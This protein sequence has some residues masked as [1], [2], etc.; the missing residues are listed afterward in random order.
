RIDK[1]MFGI[2]RYEDVKSSE[3][4]LKRIRS[5]YQ[6]AEKQC[7]KVNFDLSITKNGVRLTAADCNSNSVTVEGK[8]PEKA[9]NHAIDE[10]TSKEK[11]S[12]T[13]GT[14]F[15]TGEINVSIE[16]CLAV[17]VSEINSLR[18][19]SLQLLLEKRGRVNSLF[20]DNSVI[21]EVKHIKFSTENKK[22]VEKIR[23]RFRSLDQ[24]PKNLDFSDVEMIVLPL[25]ET[26]DKKIASLIEKHI[27]VAA[28]MPRAIFSNEKK[29]SDLLISAKKFGVND[30]VCG[31]V[32]AI[33]IAEKV[34]FT[35]HGDF[36]LN[37]SNSASLEAYADAGLK[38]GIL[39]F[40]TPFK[41][42]KQISARG[43]IPCG[44]IVYG[45]LPLML[46]R[47]CPVR[48]FKGCIGECFIKDRTNCEFPLVCENGASEI[49]NS[50]PLWL[51]DKKSR[52]LNSGVELFELYF[53][54]ESAAQVENVLERWYKGL[55]CKSEFTRGLY[56]H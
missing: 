19:E 48:S 47:N 23:L 5:L 53:T 20:F 25:K 8:N 1:D 17:P 28:E 27:I 24:I 35:I 2:R 26:A 44:I 21:D 11:L 13:G 16:D 33:N 40:E 52:I 43:I 4:S 9:K 51:C 50:R 41:G 36:G 38:T 18:R 7:V 56:F 45:R 10:K 3:E 42:I 34:N 54:I 49:L 32:G 39:S 22:S 15:F 6:N 30:A 31:N 46:V 55:T 29:I 37:I 12:K 14:P